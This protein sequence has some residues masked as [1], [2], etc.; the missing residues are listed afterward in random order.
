[1]MTIISGSV[2]F[3]GLAFLCISI[4]KSNREETKGMQI[5]VLIDGILCLVGFAGALCINENMWYVAPM[6]YCLSLLVLSHLVVAIFF[7]NIKF[8][9]Y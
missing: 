3:M 9:E 4:A 6:D 8:G 7:G 1:M 2:V 5:I